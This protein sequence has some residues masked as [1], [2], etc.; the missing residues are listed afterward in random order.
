[1][2]P[3]DT[4][5]TSSAPEHTPP[6]R[7]KRRFRSAPAV[8]GGKHRFPNLGH[9][10]EMQW[11]SALANI[12]FRKYWFSQIVALG[13]GWMQNVAMQLVVLSLTTSAFAIGAINVVAALPMLLFSLYGG[14]LADR[15]DRRRI[16]I[17]SLMAT[18]VISAIKTSSGP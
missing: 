7:P 15:F 8:T 12:N 14:V 1:M 5:D 3:A 10:R 11:P 16:V 4:D 9:I 18:M 2:M 17:I 6:G 13:G